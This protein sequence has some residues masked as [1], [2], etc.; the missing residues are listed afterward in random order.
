MSDELVAE[1]R[2]NI[3]TAWES[4]TPRQEYRGYWWYPEAHDFAWFVGKGDVVKGAGIIAALSPQK[5]WDINRRLAIDASQGDFHGQ[6]NNAL[7]KARRIW[8]GEAPEDVLPMHKKT[9]H[10]YANIAR[11]TDRGY[12]TIDRHAY[13]VATCDWDNGQ[14]NIT[15]KVYRLIVLAY[16][17]EADALGTIPN[18]L[19]AGTWGYA[20]ER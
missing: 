14:P 17:L 3:R 20:R 2:K 10:F 15:D 9:G 12:V 16:Q 5:N 13:R 18:V 8:D 1:Y 19:Q 7:D 4:L 11:P 6:V